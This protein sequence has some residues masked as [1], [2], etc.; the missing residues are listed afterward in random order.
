MLQLQADYIII[1]QLGSVHSPLVGPLT[2]LQWSTQIQVN[3]ATKSSEL[4]MTGFWQYLESLEGNVVTR[5]KLLT[6]LIDLTKYN[7]WKYYKK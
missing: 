3:A 1:F 6:N 5:W 4:W 2:D 7:S